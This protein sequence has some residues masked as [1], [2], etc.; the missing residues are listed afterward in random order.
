[1]KSLDEKELRTMPMAHNLVEEKAEQKIEVSQ[2][3]G[4]IRRAQAR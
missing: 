1:M 2:I 3:C 4:L